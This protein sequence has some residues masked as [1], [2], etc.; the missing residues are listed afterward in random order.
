M[1]VSDLA[2][3]SISHENIRFQFGAK[4]SLYDPPFAFRSITNFSISRSIV[5]GKNHLNQQQ[6]IIVLER[7]TFC[8]DQTILSRKII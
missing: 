6:L 8:T 7:K 2:C 4:A 5:I 1:F 3:N